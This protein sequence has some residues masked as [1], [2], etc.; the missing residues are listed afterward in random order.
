MSLRTRSTYATTTEIVEDWRFRSLCKDD[1]EPFEPPD[2]ERAA[3]RA[4]REASAKAICRDCPVR[5]ECLDD[6]MG[7]ND[8]VT[9][10]GGLDPLERAAI[11]G[12]T[13]PCARCQE[14]FA[15]SSPAEKYC[16]ELCRVT[17]RREAQTAAGR[18]RSRAAKQGDDVTAG[19]RA[20]LLEA[21]SGHRDRRTKEGAS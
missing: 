7:A 9:V 5:L 20:V 2:G 14:A 15:P 21:V 11:A 12:R 3:A 18:R 8:T 19:R 13:L 4:I 1:S 10:R 16:S 6:A 17:A